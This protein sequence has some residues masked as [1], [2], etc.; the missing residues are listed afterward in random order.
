MLGLRASYFI[1]KDIVGKSIVLKLLL[2]NNST[3]RTVLICGMDY[4]VQ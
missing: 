1:L 4:E 2:S 3:V